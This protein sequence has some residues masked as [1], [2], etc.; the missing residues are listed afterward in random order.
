MAVEPWLVVPLQSADAQDDDDRAVLPLGH[1]RD[2][3]V[4]QRQHVLEVG[5]HDLVVALAGRLRHRPDV[6]VH[7]RVADE[8]VDAP[9]MVQRLVDEL[10][11]L[12]VSET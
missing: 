8:N 11:E 2:D 1:L 6:R 3:A 5:V 9:Q 12:S 7:S 4:A 10:P